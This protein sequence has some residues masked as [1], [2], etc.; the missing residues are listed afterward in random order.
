MK[1][2]DL[3][4]KGI[5]SRLIEV[6]R[7]R[8]GDMLLPVQRQAI[9]KGLLGRTNRFSGDPESIRLVVSAPT[10]SGK[11]FCAEL[12]MV[13]TLL[14]RQRT[15]MLFPLR[16]L[17]EQKYRLLSETYGP[18]GVRTLIASSD[19]PE[20]D[21]RFARTDYQVAVAIYEKFDH[22][23]TSNLD[24]LAN[25]GL[26]VI[27]EIQTVTEPG[28][29]ALLERM[30]GKVLASSYQPSLLALSAAIS[31]S[32]NA[33]QVLSQWLGAGLVESHIRPV[34]LFRGVAVDGTFQYRSFNNGID[35]SVSL[36]ATVGDSSDRFDKFVDQIKRQS[37]STLV[38][39]KSRRE[40]VE[41]AFRLAAVVDW[42]AANR[43]I[44]KLSDEEPSF[45]IR[46]LRQ[47]MSRSVAF[48]NSD[49]SPS[50]RDAVELAF[51]QKEVRV[52]FSTTTLAMG[53]DLPAETVYLETVKYASGKYGDR[54][55][56]IPISRAEFENMS[57][58]AGR[59]SATATASST[60]APQP[61]GRAIII[62]ESEL[63]KEILW[64]HY[65]VGDHDCR[66][67]SAF[68]SVPMGDWLLNILVTGLASTVE[69]VHSIYRK[70]LAAN[71][72]RKLASAQIEMAADQLVEFGLIE[73][74][75]E[76]Q[77]R[78]LPSRVGRVVATSGLSINQA[79]FYLSR[80]SNGVPGRFMDCVG[81]A[82]SAPDWNRPP[83]M[84][85]R[86]E[87][88]DRSVHRMLFEL[89]ER[90]GVGDWIPASDH[91]DARLTIAQVAA[92]K[93]MF[94]LHEWSKLTSIVQLEQ[95]FGMHL[96]QIM[97][98]GETAAFLISAVARLSATLRPENDLMARVEDW[99]FS[100]RYGVPSKM[101]SLYRCVGKILNRNDFLNLANAGIVS[102]ADLV[103]VEPEE[104]RK[105][106][107][108]QRKLLKISKKLQSIKGGVEMYSQTHVVDST[109]RRDILTTTSQRPRLLQP[110]S[111]EIDGSCERERYLVKINGFPVRL[112]GKSFKYFA[113]L[114]CSLTKREAGWIYKE[115][116]EVGFNQ[117]RYLYR[118]KNE[119]AENLNILW[120][121]FENNR[122]GYYRLVAEASRVTINYD[123]LK[124]HPDYEVQQLAID[125]SADNPAPDILPRAAG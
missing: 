100:L 89:E 96:G 64:D 32:Q 51:L 27:D 86:V 20:N 93:G 5:P 4:K 120:S 49:L 72:G 114:A 75:D 41:A 61:A 118:M 117:A 18:L 28:R 77:V 112:T 65:I 2:G 48:H 1:L 91:G 76:N 29:G 58:R 108:N 8:Q 123:N 70:T 110:E 39:L 42:P 24:A 50:Q 43:V 115:D 26:I 7:Q 34:D 98:L 99:S 52:I 103:S 78:L 66:F 81:L 6:W 113:K 124:V 12:A 90:F 62:A 107:N 33:S 69:E 85:S 116:L 25:I 73:K 119:I 97:H 95:R 105:L 23:L 74:R 71:T 45:L 68:D 3:E 106:I 83:G 11:S 15:V 30:L 101:A 84:V 35:G 94:V 22:V 102:P 13:R 121:V 10:G 111:I 40:T 46:S 53:V 59:L 17:A 104:L 55:T 38:F 109:R 37:G 79:Q 56:L 82:L 19:H 31:G 125:Q 63:D 57:G 36:A 14:S 87:M 80:L 47:A 60:P 54:P 9:E 92:L 21:A 44:E 88:S 122:L 67:Q 16:S